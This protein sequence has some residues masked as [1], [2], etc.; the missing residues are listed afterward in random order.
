[1]KLNKNENM[2]AENLNPGDSIKI[3]E[4]ALQKAKQEKTGA[5]FYYWL[6]GIAL[7]IHYLLLFLVT[8]YPEWKGHFLEILI[9]SVFPIGGLLSYLRS[10]KD[11][12]TERILSY[13]ERVYLYAFGGFALAYGTIF[14]ASAVRY[15][16][17]SVSLFPLL[18]G[19]SVFVVGGITK[20]SASLIGGILGIICT[21]ISINVSLE[22][23]YLFAAL[24]PLISCIIPAILMKNRNV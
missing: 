11:K 18:L 1:M 17:L 6:W 13:F 7:F 3:I 9:W 8:K 2:E 14:I 4:E 15:P 16:G 10:K 21:G 20:H 12:E 24:S 19:L 23:Q 22:Y 5:Y